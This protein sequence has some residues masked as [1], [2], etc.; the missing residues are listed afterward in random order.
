[1]KKIKL[2]E[3]EDLENLGVDTLVDLRKSFEEILESK[4]ILKERMDANKNEQKKLLEQL[5]LSLKD[6]KKFNI[7]SL[8]LLIKAVD[9]EL[10]KKSATREIHVYLSC[11]Y[12]IPYVAKLGITKDN[13]IDRNFIRLDTVREGYKNEK[14][15]SFK[16]K[17]GEIYEIRDNVKYS[18]FDNQNIFVVDLDENGELYL[19]KIGAKK[20]KIMKVLRFFKNEINFKELKKRGK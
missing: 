10:T 7:N 5:D 16:V 15:G 1:M 3:F 14:I 13:K 17:F 11:R 4:M 8:N 2:T 12:L 18:S 19:K 6:I 9:F 20:V